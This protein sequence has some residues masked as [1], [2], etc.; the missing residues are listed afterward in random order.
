MVDFRQYHDRCFRKRRLKAQ[1]LSL[2]MYLFI[3]TWQLIDSG[4]E[5]A[6]FH[7]DMASK[8]FRQ[9]GVVR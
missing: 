7:A 6:Y 2:W 8:E 5:H 1:P 3:D 9:V 4:E